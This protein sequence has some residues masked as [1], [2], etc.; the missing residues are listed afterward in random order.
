MPDNLKTFDESKG[1]VINDYQQYL[2]KN[3][4]T[5]LKREFVVKVNQDVFEK[6]RAQIQK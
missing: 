6:V 3:W 2:E 5:E 1:K 4:V